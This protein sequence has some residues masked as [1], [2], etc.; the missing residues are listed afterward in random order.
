VLSE[1]N[2]LKKMDSAVTAAQGAGNYILNQNIANIRVSAK[3]F[4]DSVSDTDIAVERLISDYL[5]ESHPEV[6][7]LGEEQGESG[8]GSG[9]RWI[10]DP[11]DGTD[12]Y[13]RSI[14]NFTI[15][16]A[17]EDPSG[18]LSLG[19]VYN[20]VQNEL[21]SAVK[22]SGAF[23]NG[24]L[25][26]VSG[27]TDLSDAV[28]IIA[29]PRKSY[30]KTS[31]YFR[32][33]EDIFLHTR[34]IR[35]FGSAAQDLCYVACGRV[36]AYYEM[37]LHYYDIAA[38]MVILSESGGR[39]SSFSDSEILSEDGNILATNGKLHDWYSEKIHDTMGA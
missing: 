4:N 30:E 39:Y 37:G 25:V 12:N 24:R 34:D 9:G 7:F 28:S 14:P 20:P 33:M 10:V 31:D 18:I 1:D 2:L 6:G 21:F 29:P 27:V 32:M 11:I 35:R 19:V 22:G 23:L 5:Q 13:I 15:S 17:Y 16:I 36:D 38:G 8:D 26:S 3:G